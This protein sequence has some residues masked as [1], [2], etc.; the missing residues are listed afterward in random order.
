MS[1]DLFEHVSKIGQLYSNYTINDVTFYPP[2]REP[3]DLIAKWLS[4]TNWSL[5]CI[6]RGETSRYILERPIPRQKC[7]FWP[8]ILAGNC[9]TICG[10]NI[11]LTFIKQLL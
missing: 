3:L 6:S 2:Y 10:Q 7:P 8:V 1:F 4:C 9:V 11:N 5:S